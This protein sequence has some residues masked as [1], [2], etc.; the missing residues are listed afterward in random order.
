MSFSNLIGSRVRQARLSKKP[1]LTQLALASLLQLE[2]LDLDQTQISKIENR[3]R[4]V[5]DF[6]V[7]IIAKVL[8]V[9][10]SWLLEETDNPTSV[11]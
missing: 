4:P 9:S 2:G 7:A 6:E 10:A 8:N 11:S 1:R 5:T 3:T